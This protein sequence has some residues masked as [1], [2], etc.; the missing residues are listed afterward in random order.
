MAMKTL[1]PPSPFINYNKINPETLDTHI[2][3]PYTYKRKRKKNLINP[4][5][6]KK[7]IYK[8]YYVT[9]L[10]VPIAQLNEYQ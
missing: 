3:T 7:K 5:P 6:V 2:F 9:Y 8:A 1:W 4:H 10:N